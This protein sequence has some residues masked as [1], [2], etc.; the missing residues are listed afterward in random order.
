MYHKKDFYMVLLFY[1][2]QK[3]LSKY[4]KCLS[5]VIFVINV[6]RRSSFLSTYN[7]F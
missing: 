4:L 3:F 5:K 7:L 2:R 6:H 1:Y